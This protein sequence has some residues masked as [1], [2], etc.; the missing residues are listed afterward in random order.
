MLKNY[1]ITALRNFLKQKGYTVLNLLGLSFG[2]AFAILIYLAIDDEL[3]KD[4]F[5]ADGAL[6]YRVMENQYYADENIFTTPATPGLL[7]ENLKKDYAEITHATRVSWNMEKLFSHQTKAIKEEGLYVDPDFLKIFSFHLLEGDVNTALNDISSVVISQKLAR[8]F[9]GEQS[10]LGK[11]ILIDNEKE[12]KIT[13]ILASIDDRSS[14]KF[15]YLLPMEEYAKK[16]EWLKFWGNNGMRT[17]IKIRPDASAAELE[18]KIQGYIKQKME[19][20]STELFLH[21]FEDSYLYGKF[22]NGKVAGGRI[23]YVKLFGFVA[24]FLLLIAIINFMN[25]ATARS[26]KRAKEVGVRKVIGANKAKLVGQFLGE[27][28]IMAFMALILAIGLVEALVPGFNIVSGKNLSMDYGDPV[29]LIKLLG[30]TVITGLIAGS[31]PAFYLSS[32]QVSSVLKG[33]FKSGKGALLFRKSLV[34]FQFS[35]SILLIIATLVIYNQ[36]NFI[37]NKNLGMDRHN[38]IFLHLEGDLRK[39]MEA[40]KTELL[41]KSAIEEVT[42]TDHNPMN[43]GSSTGNVGWPGKDPEQEVLFSTIRVDPD[44]IP[45]MKIELLQGRSFSTDVVA[46]SNR[47]ILNQKAVEIMNL[48]D[49]IGQKISMWGYEPEIIGVVENFHFHSMHS[50]MEPLIIV[51]Q[52]RLTYYVFVR[53]QPEHTQEALAQLEQVHQ[54]F[55]PAY[56]LDYHFLDQSF[57]EMYENETTIGK[58]SSYFAFIAIFISCLGLFGLASYT[59]EQRTKEIGIRKVMGA[60]PGNVVYLI[61]V[62]FTI[63]V[64][65][66]FLVT[67]PVAYFIMKN[68]LQN[69][70]Y[71][72][73]INLIVFL[74][75][76]LAALLIAWLTVSYQSLKAAFLD[77]VKSLRYE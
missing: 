49:P 15:D 10:A 77:P 33:G 14:I 54:T 66:A 75:S 58:L 46:D 30:I 73:D 41:S 64:A 47:I 3:E 67:S 19:E 71:H 5:H 65:V 74:I 70:A 40:F 72:I 21:S 50:G 57:E 22:E 53:Y 24:I 9:F 61:S 39:N 12:F 7:A 34:V 59:T 4:K 23:L 69:Y 56:P 76:G 36:I 42:F 55:N 13:G 18:S 27:S 20:T 68:W 37:K 38:L 60:T 48:A 6:I 44:F 1:F 29:L 63:L 17:I 51:N 45:T 2:L 35:L 43:I 16:N 52:P 26:A 28:L 31:Y 62:Q 32:F 11:T 8:K 25:L